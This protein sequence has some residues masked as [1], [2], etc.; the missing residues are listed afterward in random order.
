MKQHPTRPNVWVTEDGRIFIELAASPSS[1][2]YHT[3]AQALEIR[4]RRAAGE[5]GR[6]LAEEFG[7]SEQQVCDIHKGRSWSWLKSEEH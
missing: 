3:E 5:G 7:I 4:A 1:G 6:E 2:G